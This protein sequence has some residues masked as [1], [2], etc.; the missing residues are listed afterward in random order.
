MLKAKKLLIIVLLALRT[1]MPISP[2]HAEPFAKPATSQTYQKT[3][4]LSQL[5]KKAESDF[6]WALSDEYVN[7]SEFYSLTKTIK[8]II[9]ELRTQPDSEKK[10]LKFE[11]ILKDLTELFNQSQAKLESRKQI[12]SKGEWWKEKPGIF[13][14]ESKQTYYVVVGPFNHSD[15]EISAMDIGI[16]I[17]R[18]YLGV[19]GARNFKNIKKH[20]SPDSKK[21]W[22][23]GKITIN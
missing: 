9:K 3:D 14:G 1:I 21:Y 23:L 5:I 8:L 13:R 20:L 18:R 6:R 7:K 12:T 22:L 11:I 17:A 10:I 4:R 19:D 2:I 15:N 16:S